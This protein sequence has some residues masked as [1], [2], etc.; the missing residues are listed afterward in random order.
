MKIIVLNGSPKGDVSVT[1]QYV[2]YLQK[3]MPEHE[4]QIT[5]VALQVKRLENDKEAFAAVIEKVRQSGAV[6]WA[7][8]LYVL[9]VHGN[10]KRF[11]ELIS[12]RG[13]RDAFT[14]KYAAALSTSIHFF[15]HTSHNYIHAICDDLEMRF[16]DSFSADMNDLFKPECREQLTHFGR[17]FLH[18]IETKGATPRRYPALQPREFVYEPGNK[19]AGL[20][21]GDKKIV[22]VHDEDD[23]HSNLGKMIARFRNRLDGNID[24]IN[25]RQLKI[26]GCL[27]CLQCSSK[28]ECFYTGKDDYIEFYRSTVMTADILIY[29]GRMVDRWLSSRWK[30]YFDRIF[31]NSHTPVLQNKQVALLVSGPYSQEQNIE[32]TV[33]GFFQFQGANY[34]GYVSDEFGTS[35]EIDA[36]LDRLAASALESAENR[37]LRPQTFLGE[38]G[39][40]IF[41]DEMYGRLRT[42]FMADHQAYKRLGI[43]KTFPQNQFGIMMLNFFV[44]PLVNLTP[45]RKKFDSMMIEQMVQPLKKLVEQS[46]L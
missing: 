42:V 36:L 10:Y 46:K 33:R 20:P 22:I 31:C 23:P 15:D 6:L 1:M 19:S 11:I 16:V 14:G 4:F 45:I 35:S 17:Q 18:A 7:F 9:V 43:Y 30:T 3:V 32:E 28:N 40:K 26:N 5:N 2:G 34:L 37:Y 12:E 39:M 24:E 38:G 21:V 41:R 29:A 13:V 25:I 8:P 27:G 44:A